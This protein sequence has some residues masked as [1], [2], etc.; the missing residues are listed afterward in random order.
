[1]DRIVQVS[2]STWMC[3]SDRTHQQSASIFMM[4]TPFGLYPSYGIYRTNDDIKAAPGPV[5][6]LP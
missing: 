3:G 6:R 2:Q 1:M 4:G 5:K